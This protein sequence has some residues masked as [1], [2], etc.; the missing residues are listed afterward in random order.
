M[1]AQNPK[2]FQSL[3]DM[4]TYYKELK[5]GKKVQCEKPVIRN[6]EPQT[7]SKDDTLINVTE[8]VEMAYKANASN[9]LTSI[10][11][12][13]NNVNPVNIYKENKSICNPNKNFAV[14]EVLIALISAVLDS[15]PSALLTKHEINKILLTIPYPMT[16]NEETN[17][18]EMQFTSSFNRT[19]DYT[20]VTINDPCLY[21]L[22]R[23]Y[24]VN[25]ILSPVTGDLFLI[26]SDICKENTIIERAD[27]DTYFIT[28]AK[29]VFATTLIGRNID[30]L[31]LV[32]FPSYQ[33]SLGTYT[34]DNKIN[35]T[36]IKTVSSCSLIH[37]LPLWNVLFSASFVV[38][39]TDNDVKFSYQ[40]DTMFAYF[41]RDIETNA[42]HQVSDRTEEIMSV[43]MRVSLSKKDEMISDYDVYTANIRVRNRLSSALDN[44]P[45]YNKIKDAMYPKNRDG[46]KTKL[47]SILGFMDLQNIVSVLDIGSAPGTWIEL[48]MQMFPTVHGVTRCEAQ[49][50]RMY[51]SILAQIKVHPTAHLF[52]DDAL[53]HLK[54]NTLK[55]D[56]IASDLA[57]RFTNYITQ[58]YDH[59]EL[60]S[61]LLTTMLRSLN[62]NGS[63]I[64]K[65]YDLTPRMLQTIDT[66]SSHF[67][68]FSV[69]KPY[70]SCPTNPETYIIAQGYNKDLCIK[71]QHVI[72]CFNHILYSQIANLNHLIVDGFKYSV[73]YNLSYPI[74][75]LTFSDVER[76]PFHL[77]PCLR[78]LKFSEYL[79]PTHLT[80][81]LY[82]EV[83][84]LGDR[85]L[86]FKW[87]LPK[88][89]YQN[90]RYVSETSI[91]YENR[92]IA[93]QK[94]FVVHKGFIIENGTY[95]EFFIVEEDA[96]FIFS[97]NYTQT[98]IS[99]Y[100]SS[101]LP[102]NQFTMNQLLMHEDF[103]YMFP[104]IRTFNELS[105]HIRQLSLTILIEYQSMFN[106]NS[107][108]IVMDQFFREA[109]TM[110]LSYTKSALSSI[111]SRYVKR[112]T[113]KTLDLSK[114]S[115]R[116]IFCEEYKA[117]LRL[118]K[119]PKQSFLLLLD[120][121]TLQIGE[122][123][124]LSTSLC[125][126]QSQYIERSTKQ[127]CVS[128]P[129][130]IQFR[131]HLIL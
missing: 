103:L 123:T 39:L 124:L 109:E 49:D 55:Y 122:K 91:G 65:L 67:I 70:G 64:F 15:T 130:C 21:A 25:Y 50:L 125:T 6:L 99:Q 2:N 110:H 1:M 83:T 95:N 40:H 44:A 59:D 36:F 30:L 48:L 79:Y 118:G 85:Y 87:D 72:P 14:N 22:V 26:G 121:Y 106:I 120:K 74:N 57:T 73:K 29:A 38:E 34:I 119:T 7:L 62:D 105:Y 8:S 129:A 128:Q 97:D 111:I 131:R 90:V 60:F 69:I 17:V 94:V 104:N 24:A 92:G 9:N 89:P 75:R 63:I 58:S 71:H 45:N 37:V 77:N 84:L 51:D 10:P 100:H 20:T 115:E 46:A 33:F 41:E 86:R 68:N 43:P 88:V 18:T 116:H 96:A 82:D 114:I 112:T 56:L 47:N 101:R 78:F 13:T 5:F 42:F 80:G 61:N 27:F 31:G 107:S 11:Y 81:T 28:M 4:R 117:N 66:I 102:Q 16:K 126:T 108:K 98:C 76:I 35:K 32:D 54:N 53:N 113:A 52:Y 23:D 127:I 93:L 19:I 3:K 12:F